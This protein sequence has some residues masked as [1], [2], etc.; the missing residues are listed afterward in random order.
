MKMVFTYLLYLH[1]LGFESV[2]FKY[3]FK[4]ILD[5]FFAK[6]QRMQPFLQKKNCILLPLFQLSAIYKGGSS[7]NSP[8][9]CKLRLSIP[10]EMCVA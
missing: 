8:Q 9:L 7:A 6:G 3:I 2:L 10:S 1:F 4:I 5:F